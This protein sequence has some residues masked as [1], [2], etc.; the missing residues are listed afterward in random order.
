VLITNLFSASAS[1]H[2]KIRLMCSYAF[3]IYPAEEVGLLLAAKFI[4]ML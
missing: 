4:M 2:W 3:I 1:K